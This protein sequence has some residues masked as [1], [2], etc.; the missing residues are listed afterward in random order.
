MS[1]YTIQYKIAVGL[2]L[3]EQPPEIKRFEKFIEKIVSRV[4]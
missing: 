3:S 4:T 1:F 2:E